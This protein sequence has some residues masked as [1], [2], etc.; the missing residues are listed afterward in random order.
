MSEY[1]DEE[2]VYMNVVDGYFLIRTL[3]ALLGIVLYY[4][5]YF[6]M[7]MSGPLKYF[8]F[9]FEDLAMFNISPLIPVVHVIAFGLVYWGLRKDIGII[10]L[11]AV[12]LLFI[13]IFAFPVGTIISIILIAFLLHPQTVKYFTPIAKR[14]A[15]YRAIGLAILV[16]SLVGFM[17][18]SGVGGFTGLSDEFIDLK[19][20]PQLEALDKIS[21]DFDL[22]ST[23]GQN[24]II[25]LRETESSMQ[26]ADLQSVM[27]Q[28]VKLLGGD[29]EKTTIAPINTITAELRQS[30][31]EYLAKDPNVVRIVKDDP[32]VELMSYRPMGEPVSEDYIWQPIKQIWKG[33][34]TGTGKNVVIAFI[35]T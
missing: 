2:P 16:F 33:N 30:R 29:V 17:V 9:M 24:I 20:S 22:T 35:N 18:T 7:T 6:Y 10:R 34:V 1:V 23:E 5:G 13:D 3:A 26:A 25:Q 19:E 27:L 32:V 11:L 4:Q 28:S 21:G 12:V 14:N 15:S 31:I 8:S